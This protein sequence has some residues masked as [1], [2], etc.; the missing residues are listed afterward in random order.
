LYVFDAE[1]VCFA[2]NG[3]TCVLSQ[4]AS[5][6]VMTLVMVIPAYNASEQLTLQ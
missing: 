2:P 3:P 1:G 6:N 4:L 5:G